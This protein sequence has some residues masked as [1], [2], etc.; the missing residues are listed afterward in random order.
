MVRLYRFRQDNEPLGK[1]RRLKPTLK[2]LMPK[3]EFDQQEGPLKVYD[4]STKKWRRTTAD[5]LRRNIQVGPLGEKVRIKTP[6]R[7]FLVYSLHCPWLYLGQLPTQAK[8]DNW[9]PV[10]RSAFRHAMWRGCEWLGTYNRRF[11]AG[12]RKWSQHAWPGQASD[13]GTKDDEHGDK[14]V[15]DARGVFGGKVKIIWENDDHRGGIPQ[16]YHLELVPPKTGT[17]P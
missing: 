5:N 12:T 16:H 6:R 3:L 9:S 8:A 10:M 13:F 2:L 14:C 4:P 1:R 11:I 15:D 7:Q 17:P